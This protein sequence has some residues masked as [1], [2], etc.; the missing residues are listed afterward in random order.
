VS[1]LVDILAAQ[2]ERPREITVQVADYLNG[3]YD[4]DRD[5]IG[6]FLTERLAELEDYEHDLILS[7]LFTPKLSDQAVFAEFLGSKSV[8]PDEWPRLIRDLAAR[9]TLASFVTS[10]KKVHR[11]P[12]REVSIE[13]YVHR[14]RLDGTVPETLLGLIERVEPAV[15]RPSLKAVARRAIWESGARREILER[16]LSSAGRREGYRLSDAIHLLALVE[17]YKPADTAG[18]LVMI[19]AWQQ[20]LRHDIE[21]AGGSRPFFTSQTQQEHGGDR[22]HR[23]PDERRVEAKRTELVI[24]ERLQQ[25]LADQGIP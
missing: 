5:A 21:T 6:A 16:Y 23:R 22:D 11:I 1:T 19:P 14:L 15:D 8:P 12:L 9:P 25:M 17:S 24:L 20:G 10:D 7:P 18:L 13:R 4:V 3:N 2:L